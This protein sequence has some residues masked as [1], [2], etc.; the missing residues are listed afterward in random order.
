MTIKKE[1][2]TVPT[3]EEMFE[4]E[5]QIISLKYEY[6]GYTGEESFGII[7]SLTQIELK[8]KYPDLL[9]PFCPYIVLDCRFKDMRDN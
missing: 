8:T 9:M 7:T 5:C 2:I 1:I 3:R 4:N 6:P